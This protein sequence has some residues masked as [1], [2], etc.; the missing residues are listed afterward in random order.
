MNIENMCA[1]YQTHTHNQK[2]K[3]KKKKK[4]PPGLAP[5]A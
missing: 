4:K 5:V 3:K 2:K 1:L